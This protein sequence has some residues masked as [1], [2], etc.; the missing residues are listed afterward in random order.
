MALA[1]LQFAMYL[2][3]Y[4]CQLEELSGI[5]GGLT[6]VI[7]FIQCPKSEDNTVEMLL[8]VLEEKEHHCCAYVGEATFGCWFL[9]ST[10]LF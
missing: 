7:G 5:H 4:I 2:Q 1:G 3:K 8:C 10:L 6:C 9:S